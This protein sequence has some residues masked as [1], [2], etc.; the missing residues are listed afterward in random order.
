[1]RSD[2]LEL[3]GVGLGEPL[4]LSA[5]CLGTLPLESLQFTQALILISCC[6]LLR[7]ADPPLVPGTNIRGVPLQGGNKTVG[8]QVLLELLRKTY[9]NYVLSLKTR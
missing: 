4:V 6:R 7:L 9:E 2:L 3:P 8:S 1:M 5:C